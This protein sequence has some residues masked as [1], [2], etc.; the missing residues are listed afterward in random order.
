MSQKR[1]GLVGHVPLISGING[2][3]KEKKVEIGKKGEKDEY[4]FR[5]DKGN[6]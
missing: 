5:N 6:L 2:T 4:L 3:L 1:Q